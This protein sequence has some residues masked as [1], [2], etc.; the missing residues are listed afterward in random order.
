MCFEVTKREKQ[1]GKKDIHLGTTVSVPFCV[2]CNSKFNIQ[3]FSDKGYDVQRVKG[4]LGLESTS[5]TSGQC[6]FH[7]LMLPSETV[8]TSQ[9]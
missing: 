8:S 6:I 4:E 9:G 2:H 5:L 1:T 3:F 7:S